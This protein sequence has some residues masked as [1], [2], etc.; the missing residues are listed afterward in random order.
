MGSFSKTLLGGMRTREWT[1][2]EASFGVSMAL[3][4]HA[5][6]DPCFKVCSWGAHLKTDGVD[7]GL[8]KWSLKWGPWAWTTR[9]L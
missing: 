9:P 6:V 3:I 7:S 4:N 2:E 5:H 1:L 8:S